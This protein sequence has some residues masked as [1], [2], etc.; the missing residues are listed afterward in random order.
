MSEPFGDM[1]YTLKFDT[2]F[3]T[4]YLR[5]RTRLTRRIH[6]ARKENMLVG[7]VNGYSR[8]PLRPLSFT[9]YSGR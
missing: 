3:S 4:V 7:R 5:R 8:I 2:N 1:R 6:Y 9:L